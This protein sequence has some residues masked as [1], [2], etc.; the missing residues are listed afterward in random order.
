MGA[1]DPEPELPEPVLI[2]ELDP[3]PPIE[4]EPLATPIS[5]PE[6]TV[7]AVPEPLELPEPLPEVAPT[8]LPDDPVA[9]P[10]FVPVPPADPE[11]LTE[12][13]EVG[14]EPLFPVDEPDPEPLETIDPD[15]PVEPEPEPLAEMLA[16]LLPLVDV[17]PLPDVDADPVELELKP[18]PL[19]DVPEEEPVPLVDVPE[20]ELLPVAEPVPDWLPAPVVVPL[21]PLVEPVVDE[22]LV[23]AE[24]SS[25]SNS[26]STEAS[27]DS[28]C[29]AWL[30]LMAPADSSWETRAVRLWSAV[31][32]A[33]TA[34][35]NAA[36]AAT[37]VAP[38]I[39]GTLRSSRCVSVGQK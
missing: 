7:E 39:E 15:V 1:V 21:E 4:P 10:E 36:E 20:D 28:S 30:E 32:R 31:N 22:P 6:L 11:P 3:V 26:V 8:E 2:V 16:E 27:V 13:V 38:A 34:C 24:P 14:A 9:L 23:D 35:W 18:L 33:C 25:P 17:V 37:S 19:A 5:E 29:W 12:E